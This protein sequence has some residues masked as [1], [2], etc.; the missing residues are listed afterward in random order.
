MYAR[1][2]VLM[3]WRVIGAKRPNAPCAK[4]NIEAA[5]ER[6][7]RKSLVRQ[8][9]KMERELDFISN[10]SIMLTYQRNFWCGWRL[11]SQHWLR[12]ISSLM[13]SSP[14][15][16]SFKVFLTV[17][18]DLCVWGGRGRA[19]SAVRPELKISLLRAFVAMR[20]VPTTSLLDTIIQAVF[21]RT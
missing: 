10:I 6:R 20:F 19:I 15:F 8:N 3:H 14:V 21:S 16:V 13:T 17:M 7:R 2:R 4:M 5:V 1:D 9:N 18:G 12:L 11:A